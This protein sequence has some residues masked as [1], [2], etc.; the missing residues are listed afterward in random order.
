MRRSIAIA[1]ITSGL[2]LSTSAVALAAPSDPPV[3]NC[4][5]L[6]S[7]VCQGPVVTVPVGPVGPFEFI[8]PNGI[9]GPAPVVPAIPVT[10][11]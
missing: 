3:A 7:V 10:A 5:F 1:A 8:F 2:F 6:S 9:F 4:G 11:A